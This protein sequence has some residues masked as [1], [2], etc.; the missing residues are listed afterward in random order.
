[1][2]RIL[3]LVLLTAVAIGV[4]YALQ[5]RRPEPPSAPSYRAPRQVDRNDFEVDPNKT[6]VVVFTSATCN[7][8]AGVWKTVS[9]VDHPR[10][11]VQ[12][13]EIQTNPGLHERYKI[14]GVPTTMIVDPDGVVRGSFFG[15]FPAEKLDAALVAET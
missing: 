3:V 11:G 6:M 2:T 9:A 14:D 4:A 8:C 1:M 10:V 7:S 12:H 13:V 5:R 15:P